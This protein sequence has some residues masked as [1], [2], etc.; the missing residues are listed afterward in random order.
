MKLEAVGSKNYRTLEN[1]ELKLC[2]NYCAISGKNNSGKTAIVR[3]LRHFFD[4]RDDEGYFDPRQNR[5]SFSKDFTQWSKAD[6]MEVWVQVQLHRVDDSEVFFV[7]DT[8]SPKKPLAQTAQVVLCERIDQDGTSVFTCQVDGGEVEGQGATEILKKL[9]SAANLFVYNSTQPSRRLYYQRNSYTEVLEAHFSTIDRRKIADA[10][11]TLQTRVKRAAKQHKEDLDRL[12]GKL[13]DRY[14]VELS[15]LERGRSSS[16][17][18]E[19]KLNDSSVEV[20][21]N[22]WGAGTQNRTRVL[23]AVMEAVRIRETVSPENR[24]TPVFLV[25]EPESFLHP[26]AQAEFGQVLNGLANEL[27]IQ[28]IATT[29]SPYM[30][31]QTESSANI[32]LDRRIVSRRLKETSIK[33]TVGE[34][35]MLPFAENLGVVPSEFSPWE[36]VFHAKSAQVVF[37]EGVTDLEYFQH[38]EMEYP[39]IYSLPPSVEIVPYDGTGALKNTSILKFMVRK[40]SKVFVTYDLDCEGEVKPALERIGLVLNQDFCAVGE[41]SPGCANIEGLLPAKVKQ[42]VY[43]SRYDL[44]SALTSQDGKTKIS[45]KQELKKELLKEFKKMKFSEKELTAFKNLFVKINKSFT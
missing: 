25:E 6:H 17:P 33:E 1:F 27:R 14:H 10:E 36:K 19:I 16:F 20:P 44:V 26:S 32:L 11:K 22:D 30:L 24:S 28:I 18:L 29:H 21:L 5:I 4:E 39:D 15:T 40:F 45:A 35:W 13:A 34:N 31:N 43:A 37:V 12:L 7:V 41:K 42:T 8:Y 38:I 3:L 2:P 23:M 9:R